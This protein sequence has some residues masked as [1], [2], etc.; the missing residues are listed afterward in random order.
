MR[1]TFLCKCR[2][3]LELGGLEAV[4]IELSVKSKTMWA[5]DFYKYPNSHNA[6]FNLIEESIDRAYNTN[7]VDMFVF[8]DLNFG[9]S[10]NP[11]NK[12]KRMILNK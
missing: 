4:G 9:M 2:A 8:R 11:Q 10:Q 6:Y 7:T 1:D 3:D 5:G 12:S